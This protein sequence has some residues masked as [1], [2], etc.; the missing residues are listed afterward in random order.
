MSVKYDTQLCLRHFDFSKC[1]RLKMFFSETF[2]IDFTR[3]PTTT[4]LSNVHVKNTY[5]ILYIM[6]PKQHQQ[7]QQQQ[8]FTNITIL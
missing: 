3:F 1:S 5:S 8:L 4:P 6:H 2:L 7:Q